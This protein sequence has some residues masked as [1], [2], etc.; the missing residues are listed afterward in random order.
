M[1][2]TL[3][4]MLWCDFYLVLCTNFLVST[5]I[6]DTPQDSLFTYQP[7]ENWRTYYDPFYTPIFAPVFSDPD[8]LQQATNICGD[9]FFCLFDIAATGRTDIGLSTLVGSDEYDEI[10]SLRI[11]SKA[12][13]TCVH[14]LPVCTF[15]MF[16]VILF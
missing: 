16:F 8:L 7:G 9:N 12:C 10:L 6:I 2:H 5:G 15:F 13:C 3:P 14:S 1:L 4:V 11:P